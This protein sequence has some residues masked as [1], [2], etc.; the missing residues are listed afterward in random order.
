MDSTGRLNSA[1]GLF[2]ASGPGMTRNPIKNRIEMNPPYPPALMPA[3]A[4]LMQKPA[5]EIA[6]PRR[7]P[8][9]CFLR[10]RL[11]ALHAYLGDRRMKALHPRF[12]RAYILQN[13]VN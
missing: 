4:Q 1:K 9:P 13:I 2:N 12:V 5:S 8:S 10:R 6:I 7:T 3:Q 11:Q